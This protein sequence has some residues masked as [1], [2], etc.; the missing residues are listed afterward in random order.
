MTWTAGSRFHSLGGC[1][2]PC[3]QLHASVTNPE[4]APLFQTPVVKDETEIG[5]GGLCGLRC[6]TYKICREK[7]L[8]C[9]VHC[10][11]KHTHRRASPGSQK[12]SLN[13]PEGK[14]SLAQRQNIPGSAVKNAK[15]QKSE[16]CIYDFFAPSV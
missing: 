7:E 5:A 2:R 9:A 14:A 16:M 11:L 3:W 10:T 1:T 8:H 4:S 15:M 6:N 13:E 12:E